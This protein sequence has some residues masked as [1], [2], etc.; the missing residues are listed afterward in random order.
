ME[1]SQLAVAVAAV[2]PHF[3]QQ[4]SLGRAAAA[5]A[6]PGLMAALGGEEGISAAQPFPEVPLVLV[7]LEPSSLAV[8][9]ALVAP[10]LAAAVEPVALVVV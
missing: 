4:E 8:E 2:A 10:T 6:E 3:F 7:Q 9:A 1:Q 5:A